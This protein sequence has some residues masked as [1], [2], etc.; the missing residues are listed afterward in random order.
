M[1][2]SITFTV[3]G[4]VDTLI[5][6]TELPDGT[7]RFDINVLGS[8]L[9]GDL[10][11][12]FFDMADLDATTAGLTVTGIDGSE[13]IIGQ[14]VFDEGAVSRVRNDV[15]VNG[16]VLKQQGRFDGGIEFGTPG[17]SKDD[18]SSAS[19]VL[20]ASAPLSLDSFDL[21]DFGLRYT[22]VGTGNKRDGSEK[23]AGDASGVARNDAWEVDENSKG[24]VDLL[25]NDT[26][27][28]QADGTR[29]TVISVV[30]AVGALD[31]VAGGFQR[32]VEIGGL[33]LGTLFITSDGFAKFVADGV[34]VDKLAHDDIRQWSFTYETQSSAGN[35]ATADVVLTIDGQND[36]PE[37]FDVALS[38]SEDDAFDTVQSGQFGA[39]TGD[40]VT[41]SFVGSDIDIGDVLSFQI[42]SAPTDA[43]GNQYGEVVN[44]GDGTF[45]FNPTDEFQFLDAG[46]TR[47]VTFQYVAIDDSGVGTSTTPPE[48]SDTSAPSTITVTVIGADDDPVEFTDQLLFETD[49]QSMFG[50]GAALVFQP[51]LP[52][53][54]FNTGS[55]SLDAT[56]I[57]SFT[58]SGSVLEGLLDGIEAVVDA[59]AD[60]GCTIAGIF[61]ADCDADVDLPS[62]ISTPGVRTEGNFAAMVGLQPYFSLNTGEVD[63]SVPVDVFFSAPR[64]VENGETFSISSAYSLDGGSTFTTMSPNVNFGMDFVFDLDTALDL[65]IGSSRFDIWDIDTGNDPNFTGELGL[66]GFN[67]FDASGEDLEL[68]VPLGPLDPFFDLD[69]NFPVINT[70]GTL[71]APDGNTL[72]SSG[73]DDVA[74]LT[75]DLDAFA[76]QL[77]FGFPSAFGSSD[78]FGLSTS[79]AGVNLNLLSVEWSWDLVSLALT[80]TLETLQD[81]SLSIEDLPL[82]AMLEDGS[83]INGFSL[84]DDITVNTPTTGDF[85][86]DLSGNGDGLIDVDIA[87]DMEALF[88]ND[89]YLGLDLDLFAGLLQFS[90]GITSDFFDGPSVSLFD[91][92]IPSIDGNND[93]FLLGD[94]FSLLE[95]VRL[96]T[97]FDEEFDIEGWNTANTDTPIFFDVA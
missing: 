6:I 51:T 38:V 13:D 28:V 71:D 29:K 17:K 22:S 2:K 81:F 80:T 27:G 11:G 97:L 85:D 60:F 68:S 86:P 43:F 8:G 75:A 72:S 79:V 82:M 66:P 63:A 20:S 10:R 67:I 35:L 94:T 91:G 52:F 93:G 50:T 21:A 12:I 65:I 34:D 14:T 15:N 59:I 26:N 55:Q 78:S 23:I 44:N 31:P 92:I 74:A 89:T 19:F 61:G 25:A 54:G 57:P 46:E 42:I 90:A 53:F 56:I 76:S 45:T 39:L 87:V 1:A 37:A 96:A 9:L 5:K 48:E 24:M 30:D 49:N 83:I 36:R 18:V 32:T 33:V 70:T 62:S 69:L 84:G 3:D 58:F 4:P 47:D 77:L 73:S 16:S 95:D 41:G 64:Q 88:A 7:L 40:G